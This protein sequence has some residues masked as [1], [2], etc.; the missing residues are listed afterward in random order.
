[1]NAPT[2]GLDL[3]HENILRNHGVCVFS[4]FYD[5]LNSEMS[6]RVQFEAN[7]HFQ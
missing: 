3:I 4:L 1:M 5:Y 2:T 6:F 7:G